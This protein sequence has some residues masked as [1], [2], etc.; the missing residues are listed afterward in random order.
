MITRSISVWTAMASL[1]VVPSG[2]KADYPTQRVLTGD[3]QIKIMRADPTVQA[4]AKGLRQQLDR[5]F[6]MT[7]DQLWEVVPPA[8]QLRAVNVAFNRG[9]PICG[10]E[11]FRKGGGNPWILTLQRPFKVQCPVCA[12]VFPTNDFKPWT[13]ARGQL[14]PDRPTKYF[15]DGFGYINKKGEPFYFV[16]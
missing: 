9:C 15:D 14:E 10:K 1:V 3:T 7:Y 4:E 6:Q 11:I 5:Y 12:T 8:G 16:A 2:S 13:T